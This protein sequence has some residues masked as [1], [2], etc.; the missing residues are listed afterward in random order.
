MHLEQGEQTYNDTG[1]HNHFYRGLGREPD[2]GPLTLASADIDVVAPDFLSLLVS[3][4]VKGEW[5]GVEQG[6]L[7][8][9]SLS[10][11]LELSYIP[12]SYP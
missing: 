2:Q 7:G 10:L 3:V 6:K 1:I 8:D 5:A 11:M 12:L 9:L 4:G